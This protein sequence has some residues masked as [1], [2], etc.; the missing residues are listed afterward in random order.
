M[1]LEAIRERRS[2]RSYLSR[3]VDDAQILELLESA[4]LAPSASNKQPWSF[5]VVRGRERR[6]AL[7][8]VCHDQQWMT[9]APVHI[10]CVADV[11]RRLEKTDGVDVSEA[12]PAPDV[13]FVIRDTA[14]AVEHIVL[15]AEAEGLAT[16]W[17]AWFTQNEIRAVLG[18]PATQYVVAVITVGYSDQRPAPR[19]RRAIQEIVRHERW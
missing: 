7:A 18:I 13:K 14:I 6:E 12:S 16:C 4:R 2:V 3:E 17:V 5:V 9:E 19:P 10:V 8:R 1:V 11:S 15:Q